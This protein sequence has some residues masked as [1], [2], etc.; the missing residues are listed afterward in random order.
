MVKVLLK[1]GHKGNHFLNVM[2][3][4]GNAVN[5]SRYCVRLDV[6]K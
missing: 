2:D 4:A 3:V 6:R 1:V 5:F